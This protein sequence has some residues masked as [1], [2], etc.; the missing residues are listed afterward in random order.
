MKD[1]LF[2]SFEKCSNYA[3]TAIL[4]MN[5]LIAMPRFKN[6]PHEKMITGIYSKLKEKAAQQ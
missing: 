5:T 1:N 6:V 4:V 2:Q 3:V